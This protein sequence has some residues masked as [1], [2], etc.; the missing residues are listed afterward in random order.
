MFKERCLWL[1]LRQPPLPNKTDQAV[2]SGD[3]R[4][5]GSLEWDY[6]RIDRAEIGNR[7]LLWKY[8]GLNVKAG[9]KS[10]FLNQKANIWS[11][12]HQ[13][14]Q[15]SDR[16]KAV[17]WWLV[18]FWPWPSVNRLSHNR[19]QIT[20]QQGHLFVS[21]SPC[22]WFKNGQSWIFSPK[23]VGPKSHKYG[24]GSSLFL[25]RDTPHKSWCVLRSPGVPCWFGK[26]SKHIVQ[27]KVCSKGA[28]SRC[29]WLWPYL[30]LM[31]SPGWRWQD[32]S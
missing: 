5:E 4:A 6:Q 30:A 13:I 28:R 20:N 3:L 24:T 26:G 31:V 29:W 1:V 19:A 18:V 14:R 21:S 10:M 32:G 7:A 15:R 27:L 17:L 25:T 8:V 12:S 9:V 11:W 2:H 22:H 16:E 23:S